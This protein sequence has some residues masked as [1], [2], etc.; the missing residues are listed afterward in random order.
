MSTKPPPKTSLLS[1]PTE[2]RQQ[3]IDDVLFD[4]SGLSNRPASYTQTPHLDRHSALSPWPARNLDLSRA[5]TLVLMPS[6][7]WRSLSFVLF[8]CAIPVHRSA[9]L[10]QVD[11]TSECA[12]Y[13]QHLAYCPNYLTWMDPRHPLQRAAGLAR[14]WSALCVA[15]R[16]AGVNEKHVLRVC[17]YGG[18]SAGWVFA[19]SL[20]LLSGAGTRL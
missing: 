15:L 2:I 5:G 16:A 10:C 7:T 18:G 13:I 17:G 19:Q 3:I 8:E 12:E 20:D 4:N 11:F 14:A 9:S 6:H 1:L